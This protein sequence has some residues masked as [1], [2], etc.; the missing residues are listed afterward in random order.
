MREGSLHCKVR[1]NGR[2]ALREVD[3]LYFKQF[4][5]QA[6]RY[7]R[8]LSLWEVYCTRLLSCIGYFVILKVL[9]FYTFSFWGDGVLESEGSLYQALGLLSAFLYREV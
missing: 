3:Q 9:I 6:V 8:T 5:L 4:A 1:Y 2:F 7:S